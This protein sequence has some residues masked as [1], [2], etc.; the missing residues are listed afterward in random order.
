M[1]D[2]EINLFAKYR[3]KS[4]RYFEWG[5]GG[6]TY[7]CKDK[8][9]ITSIDNNYEWVQKIIK[10]FEGRILY[11]DVGRVGEWGVPAEPYE[12]DK[13]SAYAK[14]WNLREQDTDLILIDRLVS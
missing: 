12:K 14:A 4:D 11:V 8:C 1:T 13:W 3:D 5:C 9:S 6:S 10:D 7:F 2:N